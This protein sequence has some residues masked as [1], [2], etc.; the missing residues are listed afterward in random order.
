MVKL[1]CIYLLSLVLSHSLQANQEVQQLIASPDNWAVWGGNYQGTRYSTLD[2]INLTNVKNLV[3]VWMMSTSTLGGHEGGPLVVGDTIYLHTGFPHKV[4]AI[5]QNDQTIQWTY[6][7]VPDEGIDVQQVLS[8]MCC[9]AV[10]RGLA[11]ADNKVF[12]AQADGTVVAIRTKSDVLANGE[13]VR[14]PNGKIDR[15]RLAGTIV[16]KIKNADPKQGAT[17]TSAPIVVKDKLIVGMSGGDFGVRGYV[18]A[19]FIKDGSLAWKAYSMGPD[20][21]MLIDPEKTTFMLKAVGKHS[22]LKSWKGDQWKTG[23]GTTWGWYSYDPELN[24]IYYGTGNPGT[25]NPVQRPGDNKWSMAIWARDADTGMAR[26]VYQMTPHDQWGYSGTG[27]MVLVDQQIKAK[28]RQTLVHLDH[29]GFGYTLDRVTGELLVAEKFDQSVNWASHVDMQTG[30]PQLV[31]K[32]S[33]EANGEDENTSGICPASPGSRNPQ[34][35]A[36]SPRTKLFYITGNYLCMDYEPFQI[37]YSRGQPYVGATV[38]MHPAGNDVITGKKD[39]SDNQGKFTAWD[40]TKGK[41]AW[42]VKEPYSVWSGAL[43]TAGDLVFHGT[44]EGYLKARNAKTGKELYRFKTPSGIIGNVNTWQFKGKQYIGVL[45]GISRNVYYLTR[46]FC[47]DEYRYIGADGLGAS[48][49]CYN[50]LN[51]WTKFGGVFTV[52]SLPENTE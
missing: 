30:K 34:P 19:Y 17:Q 7:Y 44:L 41:I 23:G 49:E 18:S 5:D 43:A 36:Y 25:W 31:S 35:V 6:D 50:A 28:M 1:S 3:P 48:V 15:N 8:V 16:W 47:R 32:Y 39:S 29:N 46:P 26:W 14:L 11:Y 22:S 33:T 20:D 10:N 38:S 40:A 45:S 21:D 9:G 4:Y 52:F 51:R 27:E 24:L 12:L 37:D 13:P 42:S 2:Q